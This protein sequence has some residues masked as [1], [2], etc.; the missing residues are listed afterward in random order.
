MFNRFKKHIQETFP[1]LAKSKLL[2]AISGGLDSIVLT[3]LLH[4]LNYQIALAHVN[5][6]LRDDHSDQDEDFIKALGKQLDI[7]VN[8]YQSNTKSYAKKHKLSIQ[9]AA[10]AIRYQYFD[11]LIKE[12]KYDFILTA[13]HLDDTIETFFINLSRSSG[14][15]GLTGIPRQNDTIIRPLLIFDRNEIKTYASQNNL[16][17][18]ED[19]SNSETKYLRN[20]IRHHLIPIINKTFPE[21]EKSFSNTQLHLIEANN[22]VKD[23][24]ELIKPTICKEQH[25]LISISLTE[26]KK[27]PNYMAILYQIL[28]KYAFTQWEDIYRLVDAQ[29]GKKIYSDTHF[30]L[31]DRGNL[32]LGVSSE[33]IKNLR[34][35]IKDPRFRIKDLGFVIEDIKFE[36]L[37][38]KSKIK[39]LSLD[40][41]YFDKS[42]VNFPLFVRKWQKG[43][44]FYPIGMQGKKKLSDFFIDLKLSQIE[45]EKIWLLCNADDQI[46]WIIGKRLDDRF[47]ITE[48]TTKIIK[49]TPIK[50]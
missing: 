33:E 12:K 21:F 5:F 44:Y 16:I 13:H 11:E 9:M 24:I 14:L 42:K 10:R 17:W 35:I 20:K 40:E 28:K 39:D 3:H 49:I 26:L 29:S 41:V 47:K 1:F 50:P 18:R 30:L 43:D 31:K 45:K 22:L 36:I 8:I 6:K 38:L 7:P 23:Y 25:D 32:L 37:D 34:F 48:Q 46:I 19:L 2:I 15:E 4:Q 27:Y